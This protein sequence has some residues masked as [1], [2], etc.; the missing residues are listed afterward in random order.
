[1]LWHRLW[2]SDLSPSLF[3]TKYF[4]HSVLF[5]KYLLCDWN[6]Y[7]VLWRSRPIHDGANV[8][9]CT[10][11]DFIEYWVCAYYTYHSMALLSTACVAFQKG[12]TYFGCVICEWNTIYST[13][14]CGAPRPLSSMQETKRM[15][16]NGAVSSVNS[17][18][19]FFPPTPGFSGHVTLSRRGTYLGC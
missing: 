9:I 10:R 17:S 7:A 5:T 11:F 3:T 15:A 4:D 13:R 2:R 6:W 8:L 16:P 18:P 19:Q 14:E 1:M 12:S